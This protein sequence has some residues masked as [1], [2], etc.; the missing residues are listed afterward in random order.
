MKQQQQQQ[1]KGYCST[2]NLSPVKLSVLSVLMEECK[3]VDITLRSVRLREGPK[4][5]AL[6]VKLC[7]LDCSLSLQAV[8]ASKQEKACPEMRGR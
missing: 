8:S 6:G 1:Q 7:S 3:V 2:N 5:P 4:K